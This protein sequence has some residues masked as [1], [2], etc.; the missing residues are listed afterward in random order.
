MRD[1]K[2]DAP[3]MKEKLSFYAFK[4]GLT[5]I[6]W[7]PLCSL[8]ALSPLLYFVL[9]HISRYRR[10]VVHSHLE[11]AFPEYSESQRNKIARGFYRNLC[12]ITIESIKGYTLPSFEIAKRWKINNPELL[13]PY[14]EKQ[15]SVIVVSGHFQNWEWSTSLGYQIQHHCIGVYKPI[16]NRYINKYL[17]ECRSTNS[18]ELIPA[19]QAGRTFIKN[20]RKTCAFGLIADQHP[21]ATKNYHWVRFLNQDTATLLSPEQFAKSFDYPT[22]YA[23]SRRKKRGHYEVTLIPINDQPSLTKEGDITEHFMHLLEKDIKQSPEDWLWTHKRWKL[24]KDTPL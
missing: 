24:Q 4:I 16:H 11:K 15:K 13:T 12:D 3:P 17:T 2:Y 1:H 9:F 8:Y 22:F 23:S 5:L 19:K 10:K 20:R 18:I 14:F 7:T 21:A 6:K